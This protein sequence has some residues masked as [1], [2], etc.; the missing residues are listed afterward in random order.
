MSYQTFKIFGKIDFNIYIKKNQ[1]ILSTFLQ[2][3]IQDP[4]VSITELILTFYCFIPC[5]IFSTLI[6]ENMNYILCLNCSSHVSFFIMEY[7]F[8]EIQMDILFLYYR[9]RTTN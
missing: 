9:K 5:F 3:L 6:I 7:I 1:F 4:T 2:N 8:S